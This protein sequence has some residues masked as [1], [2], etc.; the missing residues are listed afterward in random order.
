METYAILGSATAVAALI[1]GITRMVRDAFPKALD[2]PRT[3]LFTMLLGPLLMALLWVLGF[4]APTT[5]WREAIV[6]GLQAALL[7]NGLYAGS[8]ALIVD[9]RTTKRETVVLNQQVNLQP[10]PEREIRTSPK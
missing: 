7:A 9:D 4:T 2:N 8:K 10:T 3:V 5:G 1:V 6:L